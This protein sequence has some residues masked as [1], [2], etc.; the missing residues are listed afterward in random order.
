MVVL[1]P[2]F[3]E[4]NGWSFSGHRLWN[5]CNRAYYFQYIAHH[6]NEPPNFNR[7]ELYD[8]RKRNSKYFLQ[9]QLVHEVIKNQIG[10]HKLGRELKLESAINQ[11]ISRVNQMQNK[12]FARDLFTEHYNGELFDISFFE[13]MKNDGTDQI[14][15]F[16]GV[17]WPQIQ[18]LE[19]CEHE[20]FDEFEIN[21][22]KVKVKPDY[23]SKTK[24]G[25]L[26]I[27]DW[28]TGKDNE[29]YDD[30]L[31]IGTY[32]LWASNHYS[33]D[34]KD[35]STELIYL[36]TGNMRSYS[37]E[38]PELEKIKSTILEDYRNLNRDYNIT[39]FP[40]SPSPKIC[41]SCKFAKI[42]EHQRIDLQFIN[43]SE[44]DT[45][46]PEKILVKKP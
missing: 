34:P 12:D 36:S 31:Q 26:V 42:C 3:F 25:K 4:Y 24:T 14:K 29:S 32:V 6:V 1:N 44:I 23:V 17:V 8:L 9:G 39:S 10:Q 18:D 43:Q 13:K 45:F 16:F 5:Q 15:I 19:Y 38:I 33:I 37:F 27:S 40:S 7:S 22:V 28:K 20:E 2:K 46:D 30:K 41:L 35:V 11:Y 21:D